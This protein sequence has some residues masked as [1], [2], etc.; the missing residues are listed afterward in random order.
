MFKY[1]AK[2][3]AFNKTI[4]SGYSSKHYKEVAD[5]VAK[6]GLNIYGFTVVAQKSELIKISNE[7]GVSYIY[8]IPS[9]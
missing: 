1:M 5:N 3:K 6:N 7:D 4:K 9:Q 2:Q 8:T